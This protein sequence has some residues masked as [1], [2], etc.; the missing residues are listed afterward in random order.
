MCPPVPPAV[1]ALPTEPE[2][3][4]PGPQEVADRMGP[5]GQD[6][7]L[8]QLDHESTFGALG[9]VDDTR[10]FGSIPT[11]TLYRDGTV[12]ANTPTGAM[13]WNRG[14]HMAALVPWMPGEDHR[15]AIAKTKLGD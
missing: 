2:P 14:E 1:V 15:E 11:V 13:W 5:L 4:A 8:L 10:P 3:D 9:L 7:I 12:I 6:D